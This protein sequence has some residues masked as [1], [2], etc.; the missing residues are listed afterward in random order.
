MTN[1]A[2]YEN[3]LHVLRDEM[4]SRINALHKHIH[5][6]DQAVEQDFSEQTT[7]RENDEVMSALDHEAKT[8]VQQI[9]RALL[10]IKENT[11][12]TCHECG[13]PIAEKRLQAVPYVTLCIECAEQGF[14]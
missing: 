1:Y 12:G 11:Y 8:I 13:E 5:H 14:Q 10:S 9:D 3:R 6:R 7:Q 4:T 2:E